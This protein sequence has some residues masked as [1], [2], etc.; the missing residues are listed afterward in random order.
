MLGLAPNLVGSNEAGKPHKTAKL[1]QEGGTLLR[2]VRKGARRRHLL[3]GDDA[4]SAGGGRYS[5]GAGKYYIG[6][7][8]KRPWCRF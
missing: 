3:H 1:L 2:P 6:T 4:P 7:A 5:P 8:M